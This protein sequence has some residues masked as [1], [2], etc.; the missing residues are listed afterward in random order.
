MPKLVGTML[1]QLSRSIEGQGP[2]RGTILN[3]QRPFSR[4]PH[5]DKEPIVPQDHALSGEQIRSRIQGFHTQPLP[6][7]SEE[8]KACKDFMKRL[9]ELLV[10]G[11]ESVTIC[12]TAEKSFVAVVSDFW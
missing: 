7:P 10:R 8:E 3:D 9:S 4:H 2:S 1:I 11:R 5:F 6:M 12:K